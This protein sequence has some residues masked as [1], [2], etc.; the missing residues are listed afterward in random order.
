MIKFENGGHAQLPKTSTASALIYDGFLNFNNKLMK[1]RFSTLYQIHYK[2]VWKLSS[3]TEC[4]FLIHQPKLLS[5]NEILC[6]LLNQT[7]KKEK[8]VL[9]K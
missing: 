3:N 8:N 6:R 1:G 5:F 4:F 9:F 2:L 7:T